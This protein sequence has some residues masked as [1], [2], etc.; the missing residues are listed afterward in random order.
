[1]SG[2]GTK[3]NACYE[4]RRAIIKENESENIIVL[5]KV[6]ALKELLNIDERRCE[7]AVGTY[8]NVLEEINALTFNYDEWLGKLDVDEQLKKVPRADYNLACAIITMI[9]REDYWTNGKFEERLRA[10]EV[11]CVIE[12]MIS[13]LEKEAE[14]F[15]WSDPVTFEELYKSRCSG[16]SENH[17]VYRVTWPGYNS[18]ELRSHLMNTSAPPY[19]IEL[20]QKKYENCK[21][22]KLLYIGK[23]GG[24]KGL[25]QRLRQ[26]VLYGYNESKVHKGGRAV[27]QIEDAQELL[28]EYA[29][30]DNPEAA[31]KYLLKQYKHQNNGVFP[32]A[33]WRL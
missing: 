22:K 7:H 24:E 1:M 4:I 9:L 31:E 23:A 2:S 10:G 16:V 5:T 32:L 21:N 17:G 27:W 15:S 20:L 18:L 13:E 14:V 8:C 19:G 12:K 28:V 3:A 6:K 33:N 25:K 26:Y 30:V 29:C 11:R